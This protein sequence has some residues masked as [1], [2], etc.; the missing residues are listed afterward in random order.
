[1]AFD[2]V[3]MAAVVAELKTRLLGGRI[4]KIYQPTGDEIALLIYANGSNYRLLLTANARFARLHI[5]A[6]EKK[7]PPHPP[8]FCMLL[9]KYIE[10]GRIVGIEQVGRERIC[11]IRI[12]VT[13]ELGNPVEFVLLAEVMGK[14]SNILL[15][16]PSGKIVDAIRR[17]TEEVNRHRELLPGLSYIAPPPLQK[18]SP[19]GLTGEA[20]L[21]FAPIDSTQPLWQFLL[22][23]VDG[24]GPLLAK[25]AVVRAGFQP[26]DPVDALLVGTD[27]TAPASPLPSMGA[28]LAA[29]DSVANPT[30]VAPHLYKEPNGR[31]KEFHVLPLQSWTGPAEGP[32]TGPSAML[33]AY[34]ARKE[35]E[36]AFRALHG[37]LRKLVKDEIGRVA[38]KHRLQQE[39]L[40]KAESAESLRLQGELI[41]A[42]LW[43]IQKGQTEISVVNWY[44][45]EGA[46]LTIELDPA[47]SPS[48]NA[49]E[50]YRRY[51]KARAGLQ[52][53]QEQLAKSGAELA[54]LE[55]VEATLNQAESLPDLEEIRRELE[56]EGYLSAKTPK[57]G[58]A[59]GKKEA[60]APAPKQEPAAAPLTIQSTD[61]FE[62]WV[63]RNNRQNDMLT[64]RLAAQTDL[65][66][67][68]KEIAGAHVILRVPPGAEVPERAIHEAAALAAY[69]S[70]GRES[71]MVP[72]DYALRKHVRKPSGARPGMV[73]YDHN[74]T[75]WVTP[76]PALHPILQREVLADG[77][78]EAGPGPDDSAS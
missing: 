18:L 29:V 66:F 12:A 37:T 36:D 7:N 14:H 34:F 9:R 42:N 3:V 11:R 48:E 20:L 65:W 19:D 15:L 77:T 71:S 73:I 35:G 59:S 40:E 22:D 63:G 52:M 69:H 4:S 13:D 67:H 72:V 1:M 2:S 75:L 25:E 54:Y 8:T 6:V 41:T 30:A 50:Y 39:S 23:R 70:K 64:M 57:K 58:A 31:L 21:A 5:T 56:A 33:D 38:K 53:I 27:P 55:Q 32:F 78:R 45:P 60:K 61:G 16:G 68:T 26:E 43:A 49:Q 76:D 62:I 46:E 74:K 47:L 17:V 24:L 10:G 44:D 51:Q 28:L